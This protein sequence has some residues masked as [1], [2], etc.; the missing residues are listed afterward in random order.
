M[1]RHAG[2]YVGKPDPRGYVLTARLLGEKMRRELRPGEC[3]VI[4]DAPTVALRARDAGFP[5]LGVATTYPQ[6]AW[7]DG[8][9][10]TPSLRPEEVARVLPKLPFLT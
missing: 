7:P 3:L 9:L 5:V 6:R 4:E 8:L 2:W 10:T 1:P